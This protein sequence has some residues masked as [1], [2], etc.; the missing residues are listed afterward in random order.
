MQPGELSLT[1][2]LLHESLKVLRQRWNDTRESWDD[3]VCRSFEDNYLQPLEPQVATALRA[4]ERLSL[5]FRQAVDA[6]TE[7]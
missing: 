4:V 1:A 7:E 6:V 2:G 5:V 3:P